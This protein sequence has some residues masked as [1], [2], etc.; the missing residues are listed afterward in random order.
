MHLQKYIYTNTKR[1]IHKKKIL[2]RITKEISTNS[3]EN[4]QYKYLGPAVGHWL[5]YV[6]AFAT[7]FSGQCTLHLRHQGGGTIGHDGH[8]LSL[9]EW[10]NPRRRLRWFRDLEARIASL[11]DHFLRD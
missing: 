5:L 10:W 4:L 6:G 8:V 3:I 2:Y 1:N 9:F 11:S 7:I